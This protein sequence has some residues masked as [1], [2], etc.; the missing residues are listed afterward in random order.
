MSSSISHTVL[1]VGGVVGTVLI[2]FGFVDR[3]YAMDVG[4]SY[5]ERVEGWQ[6]HPDRTVLVYGYADGL[7]AAVTR[8]EIVPVDAATSAVYLVEDTL[9]LRQ[10][11]FRGSSASV[12]EEY[13]SGEADFQ[14][15]I[16]R[17]DEST[18]VVHRTGELHGLQVEVFRGTPETVAKWKRDRLMTVVFEGSR[19]EAEVWANANTVPVEDVAI[20]NLII[21]VGVI[22]AIAGLSMTWSLAPKR[23]AYLL[24]GGA[25]GFLPAAVLHV[26]AA[27]EVFDI[28][29]NTGYEI[30]TRVAFAGVF[31]GI[32]AGVVFGTLV[33]SHSGRSGTGRLTPA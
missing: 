3:G 33:G 8:H 23:L 6:E 7:G 1:V 32:V 4:V 17:V 10:E 15:M 5:E 25:V 12:E 14:V 2:G 21:T 26:L 11:V 18:A 19:D 13:G 29:E 31:L 24:I 27:S 9:G 30:F 16:E 20:P 28:G 22:A